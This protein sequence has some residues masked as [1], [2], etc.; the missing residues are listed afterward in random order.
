MVLEMDN[1]MVLPCTEIEHEHTDEMAPTS[2]LAV[3]VNKRKQIL[4]RYGLF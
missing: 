2:E 1:I 4:L 3:I